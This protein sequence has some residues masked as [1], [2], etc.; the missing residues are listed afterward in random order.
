MIRKTAALVSAVIFMSCFFSGCGIGKKDSDDFCYKCDYNPNS[1]LRNLSKNPNDKVPSWAYE[2]TK[3][4]L[5]PLALLGEIDFDSVESTNL[6][7][8]INSNCNSNKLIKELKN[9]Y[10]RG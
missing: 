2:Q 9:L 8:D 10:I 4:S 7:K 6:L 3:Y 1:I 5:I